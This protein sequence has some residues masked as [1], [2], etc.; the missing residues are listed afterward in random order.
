MPAT[1][2]PFSPR[3]RL[4]G[5]LHFGVQL[6]T[7]GVTW[8]E[9]QRAGQRVEEL[10]FDSLWVPDHLIA[11]E[12]AVP[13]F[14]A[15]QAL[16]ALATVTTTIRL[17]PL[18][19]PVTF[20]HPAVLAKMAATLDHIS[21]GRVILG[22]GAG[23]MVDEHHQYGLALG[24][25]RERSER[26]EEATSVVRSLF[27]EPSSTFLGK[28]YQ[29]QDARALPKP[30]QTRLPLLVA[31]TGS[32]TV[33]V[34]ARLADMWN[35]IGLPAVFADKVPALRAD[36][37][38]C[39]REPMSVLVTASFRLLIRDDDAG[40]SQ[41]LVELDPVWRDDP[42]RISGA[43]RSVLDRFLT[44][45]R[46]GV[47]GFIVQMPAPFDFVTLERLAGEIRADLVLDR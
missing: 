30:L 29:L 19:S 14:E 5:A 1:P 24:T 34:A 10:G 43:T 39:G 18:V 23:G 36:M 15:W 37:L 41:R 27:D 44:Y 33:R 46:A 6:G 20:R 12:G 4:S 42:Y 28:H 9:L 17:G 22:L 2:G 35:A 16:A 7:A 25:P 32:R 8:P 26:L 21:G 11:R 3:E 45:M 38:A 40:M 31:G 47:R 13:R